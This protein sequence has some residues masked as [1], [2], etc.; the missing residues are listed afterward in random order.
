MIGQGSGGGALFSQKYLDA[1]MN[2]MFAGSTDEFR[3]GSF[4]GCPALFMDD[5]FRGVDGVDAAIAGNIKMDVMASVRQLTYN[6]D[7][8]VYILMGTQKQIRSLREETVIKSIMCGNIL[9]K[10][11]TSDK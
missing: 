6:P 1:G 11:K 5:I 9:T 10:E 8:T 4:V 2:E 7:K 3:Y